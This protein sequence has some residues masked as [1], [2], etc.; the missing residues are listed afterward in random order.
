MSTPDLVGCRTRR[1]L[2]TRYLGG[3]SRQVAKK[4]LTT[5]PRRDG[6]VSRLRRVPRTG[7]RTRGAE[8]GTLETCHQYPGWG[9][10]TDVV[11]S[12]GTRPCTTLGTG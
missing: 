7:T 3:P 6:N 12:D 8:D 11:V 1:S 9:H 2:R 4:G 5:R 10:G